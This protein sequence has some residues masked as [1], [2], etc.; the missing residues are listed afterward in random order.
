MGGGGAEG[1]IS[2]AVVVWDWCIPILTLVVG[3][4]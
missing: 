2:S 3:E 1:A 4:F